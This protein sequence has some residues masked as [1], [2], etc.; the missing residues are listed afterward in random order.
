MPLNLFSRL[1]PPEESFTA[2]FCE[3]AQH[4]L[5]AAQQLRQMIV[6]D[7]DADPH[8]AAIR[9]IE[10]AA[11]AVAKKI[12]I[13]ANRT[14]NA[15]IDREDILQLAHVLDDAVD[16]IEDT[17]KGIQR[18][19]VHKFPPEMW[20]MADAIVQSAELLRKVMPFLD[21][22][23][24]DH[25]AIFALCEE[26]GHIEGRADESFDQALTKLR[27]EL[28]AGE[29]ETAGYIDRKELYELIENVVDKCDD[30]ANAVQSITTKHV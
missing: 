23:T 1:M 12:F 24:K 28:R 27:S 2:L 10:T 11:D 8:V 17:A 6:E 5:Q 14:F 16:L 26:I 9:A 29:I 3:Q 7:A 22:V 4:I 25:K 20:A 13:A 30:I 15:P 19:D 21:S 18:Y